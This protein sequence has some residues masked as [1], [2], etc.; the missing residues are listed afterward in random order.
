MATALMLT[1]AA[2]GTAQEPVAAEA[3]DLERGFG[4]L[5]E[6]RAEIET[7][8][9]LAHAQAALLAWNRARAESGGG[10]AALPQN[11]CAGKALAPWC[12]A[13]P[14]TF[15]AGAGEV[16]HDGQAKEGER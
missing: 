9:A 13:L 1:A 8:R 11:L 7:L 5:E 16:A 12:R 3:W 14:A 4:A 15:G 6:L 10:A 2:P